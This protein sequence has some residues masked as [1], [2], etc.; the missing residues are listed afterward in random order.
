MHMVEEG[1]WWRRAC[2]GG[3]HVVEEG[4]WWRRACGRGGHVACGGGGHVVEESMERRNHSQ[5]VSGVECIGLLRRNTWSKYSVY[6]TVNYT[7]IVS[8]PPT[9]VHIYVH[10]YIISLMLPS[11]IK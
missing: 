11:Y 2:G 1:M 5:Y 9:L 4:V 3:G 8:N 10:I 7:G 6:L